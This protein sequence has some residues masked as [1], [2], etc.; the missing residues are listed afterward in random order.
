MAVKLK[1]VRAGSVVVLR[2]NFGMGK[3]RQ[4]MVENVEA[5]IKNGC[6]GIDYADGWAYLTQVDEVV[7]Y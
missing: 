7:K 6:A 5:D 1:D 4:V 3:P 2:D